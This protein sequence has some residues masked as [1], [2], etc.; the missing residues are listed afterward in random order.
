MAQVNRISPTL[1]LVLALSLLI[2]SWAAPEP[3]AA[4]GTAFQNPVKKALKEGK[5]VIGAGVYMGSADAVTT[6]AGAG[7]DYVWIEMEHGPVTLETARD[8]ILATRGMKAVPFIR[9]PAKRHWLAKRAL[10]IGSLGVAFPFVSTREQALQAV[11]ACKYPPAGNRGFGPTLAA[12]RWGM[13]SRDYAAWANDN[14]MVIAL[15]ESKEGVENIEEIASVPGI[16][17]LF[18]GAYDLSYSLGIGGQVTHPREEKAVARIVAAAKKYNVP[19]GYPA[20]DPVEIKKRVKQGFRLFLA[21]SDVTFLGAGA[22]QVF[23]GASE[24]I[25]AY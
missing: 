23:T 15:I 21:G 7:F 2:P 18:I 1:L 10:D 22:R 20:S 13:S 14:V 9:V 24:A 11:A 12:A 4:S 8:M 16:D 25:P 19:V 3:P 5:V 6:L 17:V